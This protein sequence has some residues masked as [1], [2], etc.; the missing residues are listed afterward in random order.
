MT[1]KFFAAF[2]RQLPEN[3]AYVV[4]HGLQAYV[5]GFGYLAVGVATKLEREDFPLPGGQRLSFGG[6][7]DL[8]PWI[9]FPVAREPY[10]LSRCD[11]PRRLKELFAAAALVEEAVRAG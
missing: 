6:D 7:V 1:E 3:G 11:A 2:D 9:P 4:L 8:G 10:R 5:E